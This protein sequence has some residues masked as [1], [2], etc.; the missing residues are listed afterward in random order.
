MSLVVGGKKF[1]EAISV[2]WEDLKGD[3]HWLGPAAFAQSDLIRILWGLRDGYFALP[4]ER[5][6]SL[7]LQ[8]LRYLG[9]L[10]F[11]RAGVHGG[12]EVSPSFTLYKAF[13]GHDADSVTT[14]E[15]E[16]NSYLSP[17]SEGRPG[18]PVYNAGRLW[19]KASKFLIVEGIRLNT[20]RVMAVV[21]RD[22]V[23]SNVWWNFIPNPGL[24]RLTKPLILWFN[25]TI[26][27]LLLLSHREE[28]EGP[29]VGFKKGLLL[30]LPVLDIASLSKKQ[31]DLLCSR[32][33]LISNGSLKPLPYIEEDGVRAE[34][35]DLFSEVL[36]LPDLRPLREMLAREPV[37]CLRS[38]SNL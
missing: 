27:V 14:I 12:F 5:P 37:I 3:R 17:R 36:G 38:L 28:T 8:R 4:G 26:G 16:P 24:G 25:S 33:P 11:D 9:D 7:T 29:W 20:H 23:L 31:I 1:G 10:G 15:Q 19:E 32:F 2:R 34:I 22:K 13:W 21:T 35:D 6:V 18:S 30:E